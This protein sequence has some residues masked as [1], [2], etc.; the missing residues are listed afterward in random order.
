LGEA[1]RG[2]KT[3]VEM[4][5]HTRL[6]CVICSAAL[7]RLCAQLA[8]KHASSLTSFGALLIEKPLMRAVLIDLALDSEAALVL[9]L[10]LAQGFDHAAKN[11]K[12]AAFIRLATAVSKYYVCKRA[13]VVACEAME[14]HGGNGYV[15]E[16]PMGR[17]FRQSPLNAIWEGSGNVICLD[18]V[19]AIGREPASVTALLDEL[20]SMMVKAQHV[21]KGEGY[22]SLITSLHKL[23]KLPLP[24]L[25]AQA[26]FVVDKLAVALQ[27]ACLLKSGDHI[28]A[29]AF[30]ATRLPVSDLTATHLQMHNMGALGCAV[31]EDDGQHIINRLLGKQ[32]NPFARL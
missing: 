23:V 30:L 18:V 28:V 3:I 17:L 20:D 11:K 22:C 8:A 19:R 27:A 13:P 10:R 32:T 9:W 12:E 1:G 29:R 15:E 6:D 24:K 25:E 5:V 7:M 26:R 31:S 14:C 16:G 4:V 2:I 21:S